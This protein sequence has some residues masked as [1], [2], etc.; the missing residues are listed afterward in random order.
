[1]EPVERIARLEAD[2]AALLLA[3]R[4]VLDS[5]ADGDLASAVR[6]LAAVVGWVEG[7]E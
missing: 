3:A 5:W 7:G 1:M 2:R 4:V 6:W